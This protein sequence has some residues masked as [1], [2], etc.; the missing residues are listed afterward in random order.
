MVKPW[1][2]HWQ[3]MVDHGCWPWST[4]VKTWLT[5]VWLWSWHR[6]YCPPWKKH[7]LL[8]IRPNIVGVTITPDLRWNSHNE[9]ITS[10]ANTTLAFLRRNLR[11]SYT[12]LKTFAYNT[13]VHATLEYACSAWN[14]YTQYN[15]TSSV[16][17]K[18]TRLGW[19]LLQTRRQAL[20]LC[21]KYKIHN[22]QADLGTQQL[23]RPQKRP[24]GPHK[25]NGLW[26]PIL[27]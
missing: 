3:I 7:W 8:W 26:S 16:S 2:Y 17:D 4:V 14:R 20:R 1:F 5:M 22:G 9:N 6:G 25:L 15:N 24:S 10:K 23:M 21:M 12:S 27:P 19:Y 13:V 11:I 18:L